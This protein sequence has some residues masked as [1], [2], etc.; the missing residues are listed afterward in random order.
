MTS[1]LGPTENTALLLLLKSFPG[2][3]VSFVKALPSNSFGIFPYLA[4]AAS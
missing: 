3:R 4:V 1:K 2:E